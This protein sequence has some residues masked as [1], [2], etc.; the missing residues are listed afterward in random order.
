[1]LFTKYLYIYSY[2]YRQYLSRQLDYPRPKLS[3]SVSTVHLSMVAARPPSA[4]RA[5]GAE[6]LPP[7]PPARVTAYTSPSPRNG[8]PR[9]VG[10]VQPGLHVGLPPHSCPAGAAPRRRRRP[11]GRGWMDAAPAARAGRVVPVHSGAVKPG[12]DPDEVFPRRAGVAPLCRR[13][14]LTLAPPPE[15]CRPPRRP[16]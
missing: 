13:P 11:R 12:N 8:R 3:P 15:P 14:P 1:M 5:A 2:L 9:R 6:G 4:A 16:Q 7:A 10:A